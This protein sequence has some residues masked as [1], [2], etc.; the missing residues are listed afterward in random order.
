[1]KAWALLLLLAGC[2][3][4]P[5]HDELRATALR[6]EFATG[7]CSGTAVS[8][9]TLWT[10][11]HCLES[12]GMIAKV[13]GVAVKQAFVRELS[14]DRVSVRVTGIIFEHF[15]KIGPPPRQG[16]RIRF[17]GTPGG[18]ND[19]YREG[20]VARVRDGETVIVAPVCKGD[21][22]SGLLADQ[23]RVIGI[24]SAMTSANGCTF[25]LSL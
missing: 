18:N 20:Y 9:D 13:N 22:G 1:M 8:P 2:V 5:T 16:Q 17:F 12:G 11:K 19:V 6:I 7:L 24:V 14:R 4:S 15:A 23:G 10:A 3:H 21:S 25:G